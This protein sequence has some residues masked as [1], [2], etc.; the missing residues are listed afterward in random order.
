MAAKKKEPEKVV[1]PVAKKTVEKP[2]VVRTEPKKAD[3]VSE[4]VKEN[5]LIE[6]SFRCFSDKMVIVAKTKDKGMVR[7]E[8]PLE[9]KESV[10]MTLA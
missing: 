4:L 1:K 2:P 6:G 5:G 10:E 8:I 9:G 7:Y 3:K